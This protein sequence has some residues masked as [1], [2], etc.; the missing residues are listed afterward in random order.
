MKA[1]N[2]LHLCV[3]DYFSEN[4]TMGDG[5]TLIQSP[6]I[7]KDKLQCLLRQFFSFLEFSGGGGGGGLCL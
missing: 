2:V 7:T 3:V 1:F 6:V 4:K 5:F